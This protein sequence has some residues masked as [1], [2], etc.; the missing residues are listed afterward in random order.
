LVSGTNSG[1]AHWEHLTFLPANSALA[2][3]VL[4]H[5]EQEKEMNGGGSAALSSIRMVASPGTFT[6][7]GLWAPVLY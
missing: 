2:L 6:G 4:P 1:V 7:F 5:V 3:M